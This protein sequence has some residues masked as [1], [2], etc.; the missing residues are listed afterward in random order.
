MPVGELKGRVQRGVCLQ[1]LLRRYASL[2]D[3][4]AAGSV[5]G[6]E[7]AHED[8][9]LIH[10]SCIFIQYVLCLPL[11]L[12]TA[13]TLLAGGGGAVQQL[14]EVDEMRLLPY[15]EAADI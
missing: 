9:R 11:R 3:I 15:Q 12:L 1:C 5:V 2:Q 8:R 13:L 4:A 7:G 6:G 14:R 10:Q